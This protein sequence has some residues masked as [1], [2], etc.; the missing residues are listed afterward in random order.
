MANDSKAKL[1]EDIHT[2]TN[3][4][5]IYSSIYTLAHPIR[6]SVCLFCGCLR[7]NN[8]NTLACPI[9]NCAGSSLFYFYCQFW[10]CSLIE[11]VT[12]IFLRDAQH[13]CVLVPPWVFSLFVD[14]VGDY[15]LIIWPL[16]YNVFFSFVLAFSIIP[17][18]LYC[19]IINLC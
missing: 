2:W 4:S 1:I 14:F 7:M 6:Y 3:F 16:F 18:V 19:F 9:A 12:T 17:I 10:E 15:L 8:V 5:L 11:G 13:Q